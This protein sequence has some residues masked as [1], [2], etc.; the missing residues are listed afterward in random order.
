MGFVNSSHVS[1]PGFVVTF[2]FILLY[3]FLWRI[4]RYFCNWSDILISLQVSLIL[5]F[6]FYLFGFL[7]AFIFLSISHFQFNIQSRQEVIN[8]LKIE[9]SQMMAMMK[10]LGREVSTKSVPKR[11]KERNQHLQPP[12]SSCN[13]NSIIHF[14]LLYVSY[15]FKTYCFLHHSFGI[16]SCPYLDGCHRRLQYPVYWFKKHRCEI[17]C[18]RLDWNLNSAL[19]FQIRTKYLTSV[20]V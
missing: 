18:N 10:T 8:K 7:Q 5:F 11:S 17:E 13:N 14:W 16:Q 9:L 20:T 6:I 2:L 12:H 3:F 1:F 15:M 19:Q 4:C